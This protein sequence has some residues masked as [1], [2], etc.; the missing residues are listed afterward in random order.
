MKANVLNQYKHLDWQEVKDPSAGNKD[1][2]V[3]V[4]FAGIC[5][6][7]QHI[8]NGDFQQRIKLP[9]IPGHEFG[10]IVVETGKDVKDIIS[11][12]Y[13]KGRQITSTFYSDYD[14]Q[15]IIQK[16]YSGKKIT[17]DE[18][19]KLDRAWKVSSLIENFG[20]TAL[21]VLSGFGVGADT[22][23]RILRNMV[24]EDLLYK[25]IYEAERLYVMTRGFWDS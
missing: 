1:V 9:M 13:C 4:K 21:V 12:P 15:K 22:A 11:C 3:Q 7:D 20:N 5:G 2:V 6:S 16:K 18:K 17:T 19:H 23:A 24:G 8:F 14:L 10:G 25:Q